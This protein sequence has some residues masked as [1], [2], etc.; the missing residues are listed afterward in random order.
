MYIVHVVVRE[1]NDTSGDKYRVPEHLFVKGLPCVALFMM[2]RPTWNRA[3]LTG[4][5]KDDTVQVRLTGV[6]KHDT[7]QVRLTGVTKDDTVQARLTGVTKDDT[8][9]EFAG[10]NV[11][12]AS[13]L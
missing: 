6:T 8:V 2:D 1:Y 10:R 9:C 5:T 4:V 13:V 3:R 12:S 7:V 11:L